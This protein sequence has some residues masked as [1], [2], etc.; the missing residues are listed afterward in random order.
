MTCA[1]CHD[2]RWTLDEFYLCE[3]FIG[4][5]HSC[6]SLERYGETPAGSHSCDHRRTMGSR[7]DDS[8]CRVGWVG[9][10]GTFVE[11]HALDAKTTKRIAK[12]MTGRARARRDGGAARQTILTMQM[13][14]RRFRE[15]PR[16]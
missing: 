13:P 6:S 10:G 9:S 4:F 3:V 1:R 5:L 8:P 16:G 11:A 14:A 12:R 7:G 2:T 15:G